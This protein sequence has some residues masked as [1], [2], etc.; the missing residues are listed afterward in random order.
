VPT[1][2]Y[3]PGGDATVT[4]AGWT[5][6]PMGAFRRQ[7]DWFVDVTQGRAPR[8][9]YAS[10]RVMATPAVP[11]RT[12]GDTYR[13]AVDGGVDLGEFVTWAKAIRA[14]ER[15]LRAKARTLKQGPWLAGVC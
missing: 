12:G 7:G 5:T 3:Y 14:G 1:I 15:L 8:Y 13:H 2:R 9:P 4:P 11:A 10:W 6:H